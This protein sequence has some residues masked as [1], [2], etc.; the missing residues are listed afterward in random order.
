MKVTTFVSPVKMMLLIATHKSQNLFFFLPIKIPFSYVWRHK[1]LYMESQV[2]SDMVFPQ[3]VWLLCWKILAV[4]QHPLSLV[5]VKKNYPPKNP[6]M[7]ETSGRATEEGIPLTDWD[8]CRLCTLCPLLKKIKNLW[9]YKSSFHFNSLIAGYK[10]WKF[11]VYV[12]ALE[13]FKS[14]HTCM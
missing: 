14:P 3:K 7:D 11:S 10:I 4:L 6:F 9:I 13:G 1:I 2:V 8:S 5:Q 12:Y